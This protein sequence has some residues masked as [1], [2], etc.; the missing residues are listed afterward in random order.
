MFVLNRA[1]SC[2][3]FEVVL[4]FYE[5]LGVDSCAGKGRKKVS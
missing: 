3:S 4:E 5:E 2:S 1:I